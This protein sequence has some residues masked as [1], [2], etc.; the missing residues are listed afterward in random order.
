M[1]LKIQPREARKG[2]TTPKTNPDTLTRL[3]PKRRRQKQN[4]HDS[5]YFS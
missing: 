4:N 3:A 5:L 2:V 1:Q